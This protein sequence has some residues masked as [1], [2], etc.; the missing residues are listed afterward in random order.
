MDLAERRPSVTGGTVGAVDPSGTS[1]DVLCLLGVVLGIIGIVVP[2]L[3]GLLLCWASALVWALLTDAGPGR[4]VVLGLCTLWAVVGT[5]VKYTWPGRRL[6]QAGVPTRTLV[7]GVLV[8]L[9]GMF[10]IPVI[11][12]LIGFVVGVW[13]AEWIRHGTAAA[14]WPSTRAALLGAGLSV[15]IELTAAMLILGSLLVGVIV[16]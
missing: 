16:T 9:V 2:V 10:V 13:L 7:I 1:V 12:L 8:G 4:W 14:A 6:K 3:P 5:V 11:G 15:L